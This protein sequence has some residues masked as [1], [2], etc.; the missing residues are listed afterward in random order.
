MAPYDTRHDRW[1][2]SRTE[3][4]PQIKATYLKKPSK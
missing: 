3:K 1:E 4:L 2:M